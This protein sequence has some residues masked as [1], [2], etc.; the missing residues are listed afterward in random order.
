MAFSVFYGDS[1]AQVRDE[2]PSALE[3]LVAARDFRASGAR[4]VFVTDGQGDELTDA[5]LVTL[6]DQETSDA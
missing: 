2:Y 4:G 3:A 6:A 1:V 5:E